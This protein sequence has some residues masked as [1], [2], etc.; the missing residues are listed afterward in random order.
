MTTDD[1]NSLVAAENKC[2][3]DMLHMKGI[4]YAGPS[5][6]LQNF[7]Q[8][9]GARNT[10]PADALVGMVVKHFVSIS[11][12]SKCP[13]KYTWDQWNE[14][15]RDIRNYTYLLKGVIIDMTTEVNK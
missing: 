4:E 5:D 7:K 2:S 14:K 12:M 8:A 11:E 9:A 13:L 6:R 10:N 15:L 3:L 1:F